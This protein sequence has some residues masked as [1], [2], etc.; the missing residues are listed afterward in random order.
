V[1]EYYIQNTVNNAINN[2]LVRS[3]ID[4]EPSRYIV[5]NGLS[6]QQD[7]TMSVG[8]INKND[9]TPYYPYYNPKQHIF[10]PPTK[11]YEKLNHS[12]KELYQKDKA[13]YYGPTPDYRILDTTPHNGIPVGVTMGDLTQITPTLE[14]IAEYQKQLDNLNN[15]IAGPKKLLSDEQFMKVYQNDPNAYYD[16]TNTDLFAKKAK[17]EGIIADLKHRLEDKKSLDN[18]IKNKVHITVEK[19]H[20]SVEN[21]VNIDQE[22][23]N[24]NISNNYWYPVPLNQSQRVEADVITHSKVEADVKSEQKNKVAAPAKKIENKTVDSAKKIEKQTTTTQTNTVPP[25]RAGPDTQGLKTERV[26]IVSLRK[27]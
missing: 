19:G 8:E 27:N 2:N 13:P 18:V 12:V 10:V 11:K 23:A 3:P 25:K 16:P 21:K 20:V 17:L 6:K 7:R 1:R 22:Q 14:N 26:R 4:L 5:L 9:P 15:F 24:Q